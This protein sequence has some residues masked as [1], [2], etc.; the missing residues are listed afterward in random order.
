MDESV[1]L[2][3]GTA[4]IGAGLFGGGPIRFSGEVIN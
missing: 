3:R 2:V 4:I 1:A